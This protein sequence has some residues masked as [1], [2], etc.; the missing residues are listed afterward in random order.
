MEAD[1]VVRRHVAALP[2]RVGAGQ[3]RVPAQRHL[4]GRR[5]P[6]QIEVVGT[7]EQEGSLGQIHLRR[8]GLQ[9]VVGARRI[10]QTDRSRV[11]A[12][13]VI[14]ERVDLDDRQ[15]AGL[16]HAGALLARRRA[17]QSALPGRFQQL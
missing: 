10:E 4:D 15:A 2:Q 16:A 7:A 6:A 9:P 11:A 17:V 12:E 5:E 1:D 14:G 8:D 3:R 13:G